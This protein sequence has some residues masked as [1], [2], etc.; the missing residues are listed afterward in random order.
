[1]GLTNAPT[2]APV[3]RHGRQAAGGPA[4]EGPRRVAPVSI[5]RGRT[6]QLRPP[7]GPGAQGARRRVT[8]AVPDSVGAACP[9]AERAPAAT[10]PEAARS[11]PRRRHRRVP[12]NPAAPE[13][14]LIR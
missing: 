4:R 9:L 5:A 12:A 11:G 10:W 13:A 2:R 3:R 7:A 8:G 1:M 14:P 6:T